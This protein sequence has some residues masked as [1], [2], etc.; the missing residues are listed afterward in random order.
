MSLPQVNLEHSLLKRCEHQIPTDDPKTELKENESIEAV[1]PNP[2]KMAYAIYT[3]WPGFHY[4][5]LKRHLPK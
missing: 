1:G 5:N 3:G 2:A 4:K